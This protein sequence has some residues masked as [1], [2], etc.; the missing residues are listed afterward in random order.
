[1]HH[2]NSV[3]FPFHHYY[4]YCYIYTLTFM[5]FKKIFLHTGLLNRYF[6]VSRILQTPKR[7]ENRQDLIK[8]SPTEQWDGV[9][10]YKESC[11]IFLCITVYNLP[12][13]HSF[14]CKVHSYIEYK[15]TNNNKS[16]VSYFMRKILG[17][18]NKLFRWQ[19]SWVWLCADTGIPDRKGSLERK[20]ILQRPVRNN[21]DSNTLLIPLKAYWQ[22]K[23]TPFRRIYL[24]F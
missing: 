23:R 15:W 14:D 21:V 1:M 10:F 13:S 24:Y 9:I 18:H 5:M 11:V 12:K 8:K 7:T 2:F 17:K 19:V 20:G 6:G 4:Y 16:C 22:K 3:Y